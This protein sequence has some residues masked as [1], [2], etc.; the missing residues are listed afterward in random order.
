AMT[1]DERVYPAPFAFMPERFIKEDGTLSDDLG[2]QQY[3]FA[4]RYS[5]KTLQFRLLRMITSVLAVFDVKKAVDE[6]GREIDVTPR[7]KKVAA[8]VQ[9]ASCKG[10]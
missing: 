2:Q 4:R 3:G 10:I 7:S 9:R 5:A 6:F 1:H 8:L